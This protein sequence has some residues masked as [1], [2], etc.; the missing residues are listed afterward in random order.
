MNGVIKLNPYWVFPIG[1]VVI[2]T[3]VVIFINS[4]SSGGHNLYNTCT[5]NL[6]TE[7]IK[8]GIAL[9]S[10]TSMNLWNDLMRVNRTTVIAFGASNLMYAF[11]NNLMHYA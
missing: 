9:Y 2:E 3:L 1:F 6:I 11:N 4:A 8:L 7:A 5:A 10:V